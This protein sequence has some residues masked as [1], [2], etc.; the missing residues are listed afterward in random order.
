MYEIEAAH[1]F[2]R[3]DEKNILKFY[4]LQLE[5]KYISKIEIIGNSITK[6]KT[7]RSKIE[8]EPGDLYS[9]LE[10]KMMSMH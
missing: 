5:K 3:I 10:L 1:T 9:N 7:L 8:V 4:E 6:D 2:D